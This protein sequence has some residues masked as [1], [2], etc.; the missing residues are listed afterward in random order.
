VGRE[1]DRIKWGFRREFDG[2]AL[3]WMDGWMRY[4]KIPCGSRNAREMRRTKKKKVA[5]A[6]NC[7]SF[8]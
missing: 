2:I 6:T 1:K 5:I 7:N 3:R 4:W 8:R